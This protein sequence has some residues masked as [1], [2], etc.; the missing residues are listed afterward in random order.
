MI[1]A[2][3]DALAAGI[4]MRRDVQAAERA[5]AESVREDSPPPPVPSGGC[6]FR[7]EAARTLQ[8]QVAAG[9]GPRDGG[10]ACRGF[11]PGAAGAA[12]LVLLLVWMLRKR[13][14]PA[15]GRAT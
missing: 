13:T 4:G 15:R 5:R 6:Q 12:A 10:A 9:D 8:S 7:T 1:D 14:G 2:D 11:R 3:E